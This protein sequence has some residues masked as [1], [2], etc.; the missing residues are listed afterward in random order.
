M[1]KT[2]VLAVLAALLVSAATAAMA[3][4]TDKKKAEEQAQD[5]SE[6]V[7]VKIGGVELTEQEFNLQFKAGVARMPAA[8]QPM[9]MNPHGRKQFL[10][11]MV[12]EKVWVNGALEMGLDKDE[13]VLLLTKMSRDQIL[14][15][16]YYEKA[17]YERAKPTETEVRAFYEASPNRFMGPVRVKVRHVVLPDSVT[18]KAVLKEL[19]AGANF[20]KLA[21]EKS[22][23]SVSAVGGGDLGQLT[24]GVA[25]PASLAGSEQYVSTVFKL[26]A[27]EMSDIVHTNLGY[28]IALA[29]ERIDAELR[30]FESVRK[31]IEDSIVSERSQKLRSELFDMLKRKY[32]VT[33]MIED[34]SAAPGGEAAQPP[35]VANS[36]EELFQAAMDSKDSNQRVGIYR[37][38]IK[39]F[40]D[41]KYAA[42]AQ[43]MI[44]FIYSEELK[45]YDKAEEAL[46]VVIDKY[47]GSELVDSARW[48]LKNMRDSSQTVGTVDDVKRK[49][50]TGKAEER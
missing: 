20:A 42:Q 43:F 33:Y 30:P 13:E 49:A 31:R 4:D 44:G 17:V 40:P 21:R 22:I 10:D 1:R 28:H 15:R 24:E 2:V 14:L 19:K 12:D 8:N 7:L 11:M 38:L 35:K 29:Y 9:F 26:K 3:K 37:E 27:G 39:R 18:A 36:P 6:R 25:L 5:P 47:P 16:K 32:V 48:M 46:K 34:S 23:D 50:G 45:D 41:S